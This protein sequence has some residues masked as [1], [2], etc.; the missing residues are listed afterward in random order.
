MNTTLRQYNKPII[1]II[2]GLFFFG[3]YFLMFTVSIA[4]DNRVL[5]IRNKY[6]DLMEQL[7]D[8]LRLPVRDNYFYLRQPFRILSKQNG[9]DSYYYSFRGKIEKIELD[10]GLVYMRC[11]DNNL[12]VFNLE[13]RQDELEG[14]IKL[15]GSTYQVDR[16]IKTNFI[17][18]EAD[19]S[20]S[21]ERDVFY[22][23]TTIYTVVWTDK[24]SM[25]ELI[26]AR[27]KNPF[28]SINTDVTQI[29]Y[30]SR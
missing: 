5:K 10:T 24:R 6:V 25:R 22:S 20:Q 29:R 1:S 26:D 21:I 4:N 28:E 18:Y 15:I 14:W 7:T 9:G 3:I 13:V 2:I 12:Y 30:I 16:M 17:F 8:A 27:K 11:S 23:L 19:L